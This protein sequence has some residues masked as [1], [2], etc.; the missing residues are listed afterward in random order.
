LR[1][2]STLLWFTAG[3]QRWGTTSAGERVPFKT[4]PS[5]GAK[6]PIELYVFARNVRGLRKG[7]YHYASDKHRLGLVARGVSARRLERYLGNQWQFREAG[8]VVMMVAV[9]A[10]T[11]WTYPGPRAYR[12]IL[13]EAGHVCQTFCL[14][15]TWLN[16]AP[17][18]TMALADAAVEQVLDIDGVGTA[19]LYAAGVG[20]KPEHGRWIQWPE[21][22]PGKPYTPVN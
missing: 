13:A 8:A 18:C 12:S 5:A 22:E 1:D 2:L 16:L 17:F 4:S 14:V 19:A 20:V 15:A 3:V 10:R 9:M 7:I 11:R 6:H 21:H